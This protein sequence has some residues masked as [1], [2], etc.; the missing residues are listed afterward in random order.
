[1]HRFSEEKLFEKVFSGD[2]CAIILIIF[3]DQVL[4]ELLDKGLERYHGPPV[5]IAGSARSDRHIE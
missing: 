1:M 2:L 4:G 5:D 3:L